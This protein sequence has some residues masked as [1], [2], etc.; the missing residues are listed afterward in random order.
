MFFSEGNIDYSN[1]ILCR[2]I[3]SV[4]S[5]VFCF[6]IM[7]I[8]GKLWCQIKGE[9]KKSDKH[10]KEFE[11]FS[12][13]SENSIQEKKEIG[14]GSH[15]MFFLILSNFCGNVS[16]LIFYGIYINDSNQIRVR[17]SILGFIHNFFDG[18]AI[19][20]TTMLTR[21][22]LLSTQRAEINQKNQKK[23]LRFGLI[24]SFASTI[25]FTVPSLIAGYYGFANTH[26]S[27]DYE[28]W[29]SENT[30]TQVLFIILN[31]SFNCFAIINCVYNIY[32]LI[33]VTIFYG[34]KLEELRKTRIDEYKI[35]RV[36]VFVFKIFP[37][38]LVLSRGLKGITRLLEF[39]FNSTNAKIAFEYVSGSIYC[40]NGFFNSLLCV[41]FYRGAFTCCPSKDNISKEKL[42]D[43]CSNDVSS[44]L[45]PD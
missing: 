30:L 26:C 42:E 19:S 23:E 43:Y 18:L 25:I 9:N 32:C 35:M 8:Y 16:Y 4:I 45:I 27:F 34:K 37:I 15:F 10:T 29:V 39:F 5:I 31:G 13:S 44:T 2:T 17:C 22:F 20:W 1:N 38:V 11:T 33:K 40:L 6:F 24:Y 12:A 7:I 36:F 21:L 14:L 41:Y 3:C 28:L